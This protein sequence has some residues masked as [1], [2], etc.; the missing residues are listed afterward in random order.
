M[1]LFI[2][3]VFLGGFL[4]VATMSL[5]T[6]NRYKKTPKRDTERGWGH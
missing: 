6:I 5:V 4:G 3:G 2:S 1:I